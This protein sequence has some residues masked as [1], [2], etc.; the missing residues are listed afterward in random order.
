MC[1]NKLNVG[2]FYVRTLFIEI[3]FK[4]YSVHTRGLY[5][6]TYIKQFFF[7]VICAIIGFSSDNWFFLITFSVILFRKYQF[8]RSIFSLTCPDQLLYS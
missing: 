7:Y 6:R 5:V 8:K 3:I 2:L 4:F 1:L